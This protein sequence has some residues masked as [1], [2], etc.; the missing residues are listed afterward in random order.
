[1][2]SLAPLFPGF[3]RTSNVDL[4]VSALASPRHDTGS[5]SVAFHEVLFWDHYSFQFIPHQLVSL[6]QILGFLSNSMLTTPMQLYISVSAD[7]LTVHLNSLE[8]CL[9]SLHLW[10]C[11]N[12]LALNSGKSLPSALQHPRVS[13]EFAKRSFSYLAPKIWNN[14]PVYIRLCSTLPIY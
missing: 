12:G 5:V 3:A 4:S 9:Q 8:S 14:I 2:A 11:H 6:L 7:D 1:M 13:N 10:L